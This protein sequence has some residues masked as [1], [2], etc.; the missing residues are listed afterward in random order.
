MYQRAVLTA[1]GI[2]GVLLSLVMGSVV[3]ASEWYSYPTV[4]ENGRSITVDVQYCVPQHNAW[5]IA[6]WSVSFVLSLVFMFRFAKAPYQRW[7]GWVVLW[8]FVMVLLSCILIGFLIDDQ[9][10]NKGVLMILILIFLHLGAAM[11]LI[12][13]EEGGRAPTFGSDSDRAWIQAWISWAV[14]TIVTCFSIVATTRGCLQQQQQGNSTTQCGFVNGRTIY[15]LV[16]AVLQLV[17]LPL[18]MLRAAKMEHASCCPPMS[19]ELHRTTSEVHRL[20]FWGFILALITLVALGLTTFGM[21]MAETPLQNCAYFLAM[22]IAP[23]MLGFWNAVT[24]GCIRCRQDEIE[25]T[26]RRAEQARPPNR[27]NTTTPSPGEGPSPVPTL[28]TPL[29][30][31]GQPD[32]FPTIVVVHPPGGIDI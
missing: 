12:P 25:E 26:A 14:W 19:S 28:P 1:L 27:P 9:L 15:G 4:N 2:L 21:V 31:E 24:E 8:F 20:S 10:P 5:S 16:Y 29:Q 11:N 3:C 18:M 32:V 22:L 30:I 23:Q 7:F 17:M 13:P 6:S